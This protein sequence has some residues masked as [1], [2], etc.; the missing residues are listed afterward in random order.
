MK[1]LILQE[2]LKEGLSFVEKISARSLS[3]PILNNILLRAEK[4]FLSLSSTN[5]EMGI[6]WWALAKIEKEGG[7]TVPARLFSSFCGLL[8][9]QQTK[10]EL[11]GLNLTVECG[12]YKTFLKGLNIDEFPIIPQISQG[13]DFLVDGRSFC[14]GLNQ[15]VD[16]VSVSSSKPEIAG[17]YFSFQKDLIKMVATDS[18]R[19]GEKSISINSSV[20]EEYS[21]ILPQKTVKEVINI[22]SEKEEVKI[23]LT[24]NQISFEAL[25]P[26][27]SHPQVQLVS[28]LIE[29][30]YPNYQEII[31][32]KCEAQIIFQKNEFINQI[33]TAGLFSGKI[34]EVKLKIDSKKGAVEILS[35]SQELGESKSFLPC[36]AKGETMEISFNHKFLLEGLLNIKSPE[37][38]FEFS[39]EGGPAIL[40]PKRDTSYFYVVMPIKNI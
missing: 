25:M 5:L 3:L 24:A 11:K 2:K 37:I 31:P 21:L 9:N 36:Q 29:G 35:Q 14:Q 10:L 32:Q 16:L 8:P 12:N 38:I 22:F 28:R 13:T 1:L 7:I 18:F 15:V 23:S 17:V 30:E 39:G 40:K 6:N 20:E 19:L 33:K 4:N 27:I 34:N 26:E